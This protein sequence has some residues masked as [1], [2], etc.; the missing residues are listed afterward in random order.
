MS[1]AGSFETDAANGVR[2]KPTIAAPLSP[3]PF[4]TKTNKVTAP[5]E[6]GN[7]SF[8]F[9]VFAYDARAIGKP[10]S[11]RGEDKTNAEAIVAAQE[12]DPLAPGVIPTPRDAL[13]VTGAPLR[14]RKE[15]MSGSGSA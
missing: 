9:N 8:V 5:P 3:K 7:N 2:V 14:T 1:A 13:T 12:R 15:I 4:E 10:G 11:D 6:L